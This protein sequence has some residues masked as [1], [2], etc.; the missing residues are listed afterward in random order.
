MHSFSYPIQHLKN[1]AKI[2]II[3]KASERP[4]ERPRIFIG[5]L[6]PLQGLT[7]N[8]YI[9]FCKQLTSHFVDNEQILWFDRRKIEFELV[10]WCDVAKRRVC[11]Q[12][13]F[14]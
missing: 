1:I 14:K 3:S 10:H 7:T 6:C 8:E 2:S 11:I 9:L 12:N 4:E 5:W 13:T